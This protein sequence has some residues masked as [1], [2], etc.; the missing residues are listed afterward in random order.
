MVEQ[1]KHKYFQPYLYQELEGWH[2][3]P[4]SISIEYLGRSIV[5]FFDELQSRQSQA[6][7]SPG[8]QQKTR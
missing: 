8:A 3:E 2:F 1:I 7:I 4:L 5:H 6:K